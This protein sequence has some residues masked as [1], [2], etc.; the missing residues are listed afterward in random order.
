M[1]ESVQNYYGKI[2]QKTGD[3]KTSACCDA[4][5]MPGWLKPLLD[6]VHPEVNARYYGCGLVAPTLL[7]GCRVLDL[8][9][10]AGRDCYVLAQLVGPQGSILGVDMTAEQLA[11]ANAHVDYHTE[12]FG[13]A[14]VAF[15]QGYIE[16]LAALELADA[17]FDVIVSNC[18]INLSPDKDSVLREAH[19]LLK[20]GGELYFSDVYADRRLAKEL[21]EDEVLYGECLGGALYWN[22]FEN[23]ARRHGFADP[24]L[25]EDRPISVDDP[26]LAEKLG[27]ARFFSATYRL[28]KLDGLEPACEDYGQAVI[29]QGS[30]PGAASAFVLDKHHRIETGRVFPVCG[31]TWRMLKDSRFAAHFQ[32]IGDF[33]RH[34]G[35]FTGCGAGLPFDQPN[36][37]AP[38][39]SCC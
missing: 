30:I 10:G 24:R 29:Y 13:Y 6:K 37:A 12:R 31:N 3:L 18:V 34:F 25:V 1:H 27:D 17:S 8:G 38:A 15:R 23:L 26:H 16:D 36:A 33:S 39:A 21:R 14:N 19:R 20:P 5:S 2:L 11:V 7:E 9:S 35:I 4:S 32:F 22:D 28:F